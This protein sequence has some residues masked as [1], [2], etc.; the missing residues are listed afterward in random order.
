MRAPGSASSWERDNDDDGR[1]RER[2]AS[3]VPLL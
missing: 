1:G 3:H 2:R